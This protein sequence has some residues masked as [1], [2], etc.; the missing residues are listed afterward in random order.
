MTTTKSAAQEAGAMAPSQATDPART[1]NIKTLDNKKLV[2][3]DTDKLTR[4]AMRLRRDVLKMV[5]RAGSGHP[6][7][8]FSELEVLLALYHGGVMR[9]NTSN[10]KD[11]RRDQFILSKG[12]AAPGLY[13]VLADLGYFP[14]EELWRLRRIEGLLQGHVDRKIPGIEMSAG[15]LGMGPGFGNGIAL[16][17]RLDKNDG[18]I[19]IMV[20][21][22]EIQEGQVWE[23]F[24]T[25]A[26]YR[27]DNVCLIVDWNKY[28]IDGSIEDIRSL[29][30]IADK[31]RAFDWHV[32]EIDG[33]DLDQLFAAFDEAAATKGKPTCIVANT[34]KGHGVS[35]MSGTAA[36]HGKAPNADEMA[37]AMEELGAT[38][39]E[40]GRG[41]SSNDTDAEV[42]L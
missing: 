26:H 35:F 33:H 9:I 38:W 5:Y 1:R 22:G 15:S 14:T 18:R 27:L 20:G 32:I 41:W 39:D 10:T 25:A 42:Y 19:Y 23:A 7:G 34:S 17:H 29:G 4:V 21:D 16:A 3:R 13:A 40:E 28:Q 6:G 36:F 11:E 30:R 31:F 12:H 24:M 37:R 2:G 8:S